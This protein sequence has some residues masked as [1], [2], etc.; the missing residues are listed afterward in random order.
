MTGPRRSRISP[1]LPPSADATIEAWLRWGRTKLSAL[2]DPEREARLLMSALLSSQTAPWT[3]SRERLEEELVP[4]YKDWIKRRAA[5]EPHH[6][7]TGEITFY[8][9]SFFL[10]PGVLVPRPETEQLVELALQHTTA[11]KGRDPLRILDLG[12]GSGVIALSF[13]L[14][15][16]DAQAVAVER[17]PLALATL[18]EN[19]RRHRLDDRLAVVRGDWEEMFGEHPV[20]D[21]ILSNPPYIPTDKIPKLEPEVR[22]YEPLSA[23]DGGADGLDPYRKILPRAFRLLRKEGLI[24]LEIGDDMGDSALFSDMTG[25]TGDTTPLPTIIRDISGRHRIVFWTG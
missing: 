18:L 1:E 6:L 19:R 4:R 13:L 20:F 25:K 3:R 10:S 15:R 21:C 23:L 8:G 11:F 7:I 24:A 17:E 12:A 22:I 9:H 16:P 2:E 14:E 5:R